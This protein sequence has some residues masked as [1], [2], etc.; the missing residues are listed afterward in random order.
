MKKLIPFSVLLAF[1]VIASLS[2]C[3]KEP[4]N[5]PPV[6]QSISA[7]PNSSSSNRIPGGTVVQLTVVA[8]D[9]DKDPLTYTWSASEGQ[10]N[11]DAD[12][13]TV[14]W[15]APHNSADKNYD[16][17]V[18]VSDGQKAVNSQIT[19][20]IAKTLT[21][22]VE[23][24][25]FY[26]S[27]TIPVAG[28]LISVA[29]KTSTTESN[30]FYQ[31]QDVPSG[32]H[33]LT[34]TK[35]GYDTYSSNIEFQTGDNS[36]NI[37]MTSA[38]NTHN[39][40]GYVISSALNT[41]VA[42]CEVV[43]LNPDGT[44]SNL[45]TQTSSNGYFQIPTVPQGSRIIRFTHNDHEL[46]ETSI[47][48]A[49]S[50]YEL[51]ITVQKIKP[52]VSTSNVFD[53]QHYCAKSGGEVLHEGSTPV[54]SRGV[55]WSIN[56]NPT[57]S[58]NFTTDNAGLGI[59][60]SQLY[61]LSLN[62]TYFLRAYATNSGGTSYGLEMVFT[63]TF[64]NIGDNF[65]GGKLAYILQPTDPGYDPCEV[66]GLI[67]APSDLI[68]S[69]WGCYDTFIGGTSTAL[70]TGAANTGA[71]VAGCNTAGIAARR[72]YGLELNGYS[73]WFLP[74]KDEL[75]KLYQN[76][77]LI[78]GF[79]EDGLPYWSSFEYDSGRAGFQN[80]MNGIQYYADKSWTG[81]VRA[82]RAF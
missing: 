24:Y 38:L 58:D 76:R 66:H 15:M 41:P 18:T 7:N 82:V 43:V 55:C 56:Q 51:N 17:T 78:G 54:I 47:F 25:T 16:I 48:M 37:E 8:T 74:S 2:S 81:R 31:I 39:L 72:C 3:E 34:A 12:K 49:N 62:A 14:S 69:K 23:G 36:L 70:G 67:A 27:T 75:N 71:I 22:K 21:G 53:I 80:F 6:I 1:A 32:N 73:D 35:E 59:F 45:K 11:T 28:V 4:E 26:A 29:G 40:Y 13:A 44:E 9:P 10:F 50:N 61:G 60:S 30:G 33:T 20:Y 65:S 5:Q 77:S 42:F 46:L 68:S 79:V 64:P 63:I 57:L 52:T 19:K